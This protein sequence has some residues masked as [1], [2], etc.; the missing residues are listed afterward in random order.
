MERELQQLIDELGEAINA[1]LSNS[2]RFAEIMSE[3][4]RTGYDVFVVLEASIGV[5]KNGEPLTGGMEIPVPVQKKSGC[6]EE[7]QMSADDLEFLRELNISA[8]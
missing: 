1:S 7:L 8:R 3:M 4:E 6:I 5:R 2:D